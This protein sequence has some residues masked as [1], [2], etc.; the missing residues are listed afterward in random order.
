MLATRSVTA[1]T[2]AACSHWRSEW[3]LSLL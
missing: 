3:S 1:H 2:L